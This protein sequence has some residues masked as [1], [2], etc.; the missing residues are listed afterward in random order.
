MNN[1]TVQNLIKE[2]Y[3]PF[4]DILHTSKTEYMGSYQKRVTDEND[5]KYFINVNIYDLSKIVVQ[6]DDFSVSSEAQFHNEN[7]ETFNVE[8]FIDGHTIKQ[9]EDFFEKVWKL[10]SKVYYS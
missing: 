10:M 4:Q 7:G 8:Y 9:M 3:K 5:T 6:K 2:G 1:I